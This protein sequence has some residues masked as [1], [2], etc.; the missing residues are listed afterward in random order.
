MHP[1]LLPLLY[2]CSAHL[3]ISHTRRWLLDFSVCKVKGKACMLA[4][5]ALMNSS[6]VCLGTGHAH[7]LT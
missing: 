7:T 1:P 2:A 6:F 3:E 4:M 5:S